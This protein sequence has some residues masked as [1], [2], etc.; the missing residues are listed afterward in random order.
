MRAKRLTLV[1]IATS[2]LLAF[3]NCSSPVAH[4]SKETSP[5]QAADSG[6][7]PYDGKP[8]I[9]PAE[10]C[11]DGSPKARIV[12]HNSN[13]AFIVR[14]NCQ[15]QVPAPELT[16]EEFTVDS[17]DVL[18]LGARNFVAE[19]GYS[20]K[21]APMSK[22]YPQLSGNVSS[23]DP[24]KIFVIDF[25]TSP[26]AIAAMKQA[27]RTVICN[28]SAGTFEPWRADAASFPAGAQGNP[29]GANG[30]KYLDIRNLTVRSL[31][32][33]RIV[34]AASL[35]CDGVDL[36]SL[37]SYA[38]NTGFNITNNISIDY[39]RYL[40]QIAHDRGLAV[41]VHAG[42]GIAPNIASFVEGASVEQCY[43]YS[44]CAPYAAY[45]SAGKAV[46]IIEH[47]PFSAGLCAQ[48]RAS[49][50]SLVFANAELDGRSFQSCP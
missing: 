8:Y 12:Y 19:E 39:V 27:G 43:Q 18:H 11:P 23:T 42:P 28:F 47:T 40:S 31:M 35:G 41:S 3:Q 37:D 20:A 34:E 9:D 32:A 17:N 22:F 30:E 6:G 38:N 10:P 45:P 26:Q 29:V 36:D 21:L 4:R 50:F 13:S 14:D 44:E 25:S 7:Q 49:G 1:M 24:A 16:G 15:A 2:L 33:D 48:A 5:N 46:L